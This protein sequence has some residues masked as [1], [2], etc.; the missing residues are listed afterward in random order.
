MP[1]FSFKSSCN[2][3][4]GCKVKR[5]SLPSTDDYKFPS[6]PSY[7]D[8]HPTIKETEVTTLPLIDSETIFPI[9]NVSSEKQNVIIAE[10]CSTSNSILSDPLV[11]QSKLASFII[12]SRL[13]RSSA[14]KLLK[15]LKSV[16]SLECL[17]SL[18]IDSRT[19]LSTPRT[20][21]VN[22]TNIGGGKY[23]HFGIFH[24]L[25]HVLKNV[26]SI[27]NLHVL[28]LWFNIDGLP[29]DKKGK[30]FWPILCSF[31]F[32]SKLTNPFIIGAY[33]EK[34]NHIAWKSIFNLLLKNSTICL[35][36]V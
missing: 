24:G 1:K 16:D 35:H 10:N 36:M 33:F 8:V 18:P 2:L 29:V 34:K 19:L 21:L 25:S 30:S 17:K 15:L 7:Q 9:G 14:T 12:S 3:S 6:L 20:G 28:E 13:P 23:I 22:I 5:L 32:E 31:L 11:F 27:Q 4:N 26:A